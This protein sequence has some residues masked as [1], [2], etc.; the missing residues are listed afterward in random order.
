MEIVINPNILTLD[1][2]YSLHSSP[3]ATPPPHSYSLTSTLKLI[4]RGYAITLLVDRSRSSVGVPE[5]AA[6][7][8]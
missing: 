7:V 1:N 4:I 3:F 2:N 8:R 5:V 6:R